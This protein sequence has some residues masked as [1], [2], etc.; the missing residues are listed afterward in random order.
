MTNDTDRTGWHALG[1]EEVLARLHSNA[2]GLRSADAAARL[3]REGANALEADEGDSPLHLLLHQVNNPLIYLLIA[4]AAVSLLTGHMTDAAVIAG[5]VVLNTVLGF[6][7]EW[8]AEGALAALRR[9]SAPKA[10]VVRDGHTREIDASEIVP[11]DILALESGARVPA[12]AYLLRS[13]ELKVDESALTGESEPVSKRPGQSAHDAPVADRFNMVWM[14][15]AVTAGRGRA[16]AVATGMQ[17]EMG[18]IAGQMRGI[19]RGK[20]PLQQRLDTLGMWIGAGSVALA[21]VVFV[22][23]MLRGYGWLEMLL[24]AVAVAV[25]AIPEGLPAVINVTLALGV[26]RMADRHAIVRRLPAVETLGSTTVICSD[27]TGTITRNQM[28]VV[29]LHAA[30]HGCVVTGEGYAP[31]GDIRTEDGAPLDPLPDPVALVLR[32]GALSNNANLVN[33]DGAWRVEGNPS[34]GALLVAAAK[35]GLVRRDLDKTFVRRAELPFSSD[36]KYM[37]TLHDNGDGGRVLYVKG[38]PERILSFCSHYLTGDGPAPL[39][40]DARARIDATAQQFAGDA[41]RVMAGACKEFHGDGIDRAEAETGLTFV[42]LWGIIDPPRDESAAAVAAARDA[43]IK[44]VMITGDHATTAMAI[45]RRV[46]ISDKTEA[47]SGS[48]V[49]GLEG[50]ALAARVLEVRTLARVS[51]SHKLRVM[52]AL[53]E[54]GEV[55]AMTGDG[56]NDA[57]ALKGADIGVAMGITGTEVAKEAADMVLTDDNF[58]TIV[59]AVEEGRVIYS[60]LQRVIFFLLATNLGEILTLTGALIVGLE[61]PLTAAMIL[62]VNLVTDGACTIPLGVEPRHANVLK[63]PPRQPGASI[64]DRG[65]LAR[66]TVLTLVMAVGTLGLFWYEIRTGTIAHAQTIAFTTL[67]AFQWWQ[68]LNARSRSESIFRVG[69]LGNRWLLAGLAA[70]VVLQIGVV[71]TALGQQ[72]FGTVSLTAFD[73]LLIVLVSSSIWVVD[74]TRKLLGWFREP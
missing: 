43:G 3:E 44:T 29:R 47:I 51:P 32:L 6:V 15:T 66:M 61:L 28:T 42:G 35:A 38:A 50:P 67:A 22:L 63:H 12:D 11:G 4:A 71:H 64:L 54:H 17:T 21:G 36:A 73:W 59:H 13:D 1:S 25:S 24:F 30:G 18:T 26:R 2:E 23:G 19:D 34:E 33:E 14:S 56:V 72:L 74:E 31:D 62:W 27:K 69:L 48:E 53:K 5:V 55:V 37:A 70:A 20:T 49:D 39:D 68:A 10:H 8:R 45:A 16:I 41:L 58:A 52:H 57:P 40:D 7:Q 60:N 46:G 9:M 65:A